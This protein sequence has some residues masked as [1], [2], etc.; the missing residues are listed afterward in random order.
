M[1]AGELRNYGTI[2]KPDDAGSSIN[3]TTTWHTYATVFAKIQPV[4][5]NESIDDSTKKSQANVT[6]FITIRFIRGLD[7]SMRFNFD[8]RIL[9]FEVI[10]NIDERDRMVGIRRD[11]AQRS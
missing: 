2:E 4:R 5:G 7:P 9:M 6:H 10:R 11:N 1:R 8:G 3:G